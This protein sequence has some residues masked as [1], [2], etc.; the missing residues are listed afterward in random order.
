[1]RI[2]NV[3]F[4]RVNIPGA[5]GFRNLF[6][7]CIIIEKRA[8]KL[9]VCVS[10]LRQDFFGQVCVWSESGTVILVVTMYTLVHGCAVE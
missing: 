1:M 6:I 7:V 2:S 3:I 8:C 10:L 9:C 5:I 4:T